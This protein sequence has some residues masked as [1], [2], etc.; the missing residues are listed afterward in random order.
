MS[1]HFWS[2][3]FDIFL[4]SDQN[5]KTSPWCYFWCNLCNCTTRWKKRGSYWA[6]IMLVS[7]IRFNGN[8]PNK[9]SF[10]DIKSFTDY[11]NLTE[12]LKIL[13]CLAIKS[14]TID[15]FSG[16]NFNYSWNVGNKYFILNGSLVFHNKQYPLFFTPA[17]L[18]SLQ[19]KWLKTQPF[20]YD[21]EMADILYETH[22]E[23][24]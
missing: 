18:H 20:L 4:D 23:Q 2:S 10:L 7:W 3:I 1:P 11:C 16:R 9:K 22:Q 15:H 12:L 6:N 14:N 19:G 21:E 17:G 13:N 5:F 8:N 24:E